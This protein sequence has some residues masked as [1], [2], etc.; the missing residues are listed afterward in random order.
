LLA[1]CAIAWPVRASAE[2]AGAVIDPTVSPTPGIDPAN[3]STD[4]TPQKTGSAI[5]PIFAPIPF[6]NT[7]L[8]WGLAVMAGAIH[9]FDPDTTLKPSTGAVTGF[10]T[11]N[12]SWGVMAL[13]MARLA[14]DT[15]RVRG[16]AS[17]VDVR[18]DFYGVGEDAGNAGKS[19]AIEQ[20]MDFAVGSVLRRVTPESTEA[21]CCCGF[22]ARSRC[23]T[24]TASRCLC[25]RRIW[26]PPISS[27]PGRRRSS[28]P[29]TTT[30]GRGADRSHRARRISSPRASAARGTSSATW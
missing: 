20:P 30:T 25:R 4:G 17:H 13:E 23:R 1:A 22:A 3:A 16:L 21:C 10:Y 15:W 26:P 28:T 5:T 8:G 11:E 18:Y 6:K 9:R 29:A 2:A 7:Q 19:V 12:K 27:H 14:H 24:I